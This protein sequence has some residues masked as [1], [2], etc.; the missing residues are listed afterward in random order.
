MDNL[1]IVSKITFSN[2]ELTPCI[3]ILRGI[4]LA[5]R[6]QNAQFAL[7]MSFSYPSNGVEVSTEK[8][9]V[10]IN[11]TR[12]VEDPTPDPVWCEVTAPAIT[13]TQAPDR[14]ALYTCN[15]LITITAVSGIVTPCGDV[16]STR[17][18]ISHT[19]W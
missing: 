7:E 17:L 13:L 11:K 5:S 3:R 16:D 4:Q 14:G 12:G 6:Q 9:K 15:A 18:Q 1:A 19:G 2:G 10:L 8:V